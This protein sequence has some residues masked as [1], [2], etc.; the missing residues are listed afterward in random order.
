MVFP[1]LIIIVSLLALCYVA[2]LCVINAGWHRLNR[3][4][5]P[6][7]TSS[8]LPFISVVIAV[9]N[10]EK[11]I[12]PLL[13]S[14]LLQDYPTERYEVIVI[15]DFSSDNT[16]LVINDFIAQHSLTNYYCFKN[17]DPAMSGKKGALAKGI[18]SAV[19]EIVITTDAD[20]TMGEKWLHSLASAFIQN[21]PEMVIGPVDIEADKSLFSAFQSLEYMSITGVTAGAAVWGIPVMCS[22][23][24]LAF[25][26]EAY[27]ALK[28]KLSGG[29]Y[30]SGDDVFLMITL[31]KVYPD[32][33]IFLKDRE[34]LIKTQPSKGISYFMSQRMRWASKA[35]GYNDFAVIYT[36][37]IVALFNISIAL[38]GIISLSGLIPLQIPVYLWLIKFLADFPLL[39]HVSRFLDK[40]TLLRFYIPLQIIYP[41][42]VV[43]TLAGSRIMHYTW[44]N[45]KIALQ[46]LA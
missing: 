12:P 5:P 9:R 18:E 8:S 22:G 45:R 31:K 24:N 16:I 33:I 1:V 3:Q 43:G 46:C 38:L 6:S 34:A 20:C 23:A 15:D 26:R 40:G 44:K 7:I 17:D 25:R 21:S 2:M 30:Q 29:N 10:E 19:G 4:K 41:F 28:N 27:S 32:K 36:G 35:G 14:L 39:Y 37:L 11:T 13:N 42:Y